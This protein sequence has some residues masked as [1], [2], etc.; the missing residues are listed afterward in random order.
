MKVLISILAKEDNNIYSKLEE[1]IRNTWLKIKPNNVD[2]IFYYG[3][4]KNELIGD[5]LYLNIPDTY[6]T[7]SQKTVMMY[8]YIYNNMNNYDYIF[9]TNLSSYVD[10]PLLVDFLT[11]KPKEK[12]YCGIKGKHGSIE[13]AS[14]SGYFISKDL[15]KLI[16]DNQNDW[17]NNIIDDLAAGKFMKKYNIKINENAKRED[18]DINKITN[19]TK[20][21]HYRC[22]QKNRLDDIKLMY[23]IYNYGKNRTNISKKN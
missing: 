10:I 2:V 14:G 22:K 15:L 3:N 12:F 23:K 5:S 4:G 6:N 8:N 17:D 21:Y 16:V 20:K 9:R 19:I 7:I 11:D 13:F 18:L 1:T